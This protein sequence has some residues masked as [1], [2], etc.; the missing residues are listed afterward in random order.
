MKRP[1]SMARPVAQWLLRLTLSGVFVY[2]GLAKLHDPHVFSESIASFRL[3][4]PALINLSTLTLPPME[5]LAGLLALTGGR[6]RRCGAFALLVMLAVFLVALA[7]AQAR[8]LNV[9]CGCFGPDRFDALAP[10]KNLWFAMLRDAVLGAAAWLL[11]S[12][13]NDGDAPTTT[14]PTKK[15]RQR[16]T[17]PGLMFDADVRLADQSRRA[18]TGR[19]AA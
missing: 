19:P 4:P 17:S 6:L 18:S 9:D 2:A 7:Q 15:P 12:A 1:E 13:A 10:T 5:I 11:Y 3:L 14:D 8:G 16:R